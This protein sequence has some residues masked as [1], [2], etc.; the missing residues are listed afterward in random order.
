MNTFLLLT[1]AALAGGAVVGIL[2]WLFRT[3]YMR[4]P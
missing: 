4:G 2:V 3:C 1:G